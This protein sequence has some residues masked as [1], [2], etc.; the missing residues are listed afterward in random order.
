MTDL[1]IHVCEFVVKYFLKEGKILNE[2]VVVKHQ[3]I[4]PLFPLPYIHLLSEVLPIDWGSA[5]WWPKSLN[6]RTPNCAIQRA[7]GSI[8]PVC[9]PSLCSL[10]KKI[11][12]RKLESCGK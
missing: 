11:S 2:G 6:V 10:T 7:G 3:N 4:S 5:G 1:K 9:S 12:K 8:G